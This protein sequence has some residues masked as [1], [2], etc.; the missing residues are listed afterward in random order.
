[1]EGWCKFDTYDHVWT[2]K[3]K[4]GKKTFIKRL[5]PSR[6]NRIRTIYTT[7]SS[8]NKIYSESVFINIKK[9]FEFNKSHYLQTFAVTGEDLWTH[10]ELYD[11]FQNKRELQNLLTV[12]ILIV[13]ELEKKYNF[14]HGDMNHYN[15]VISPALY[16]SLRNTE[17]GWEH[18]LF[19]YKPVLI[20]LDTS[21]GDFNG[22]LV[23]RDRDLTN[24][25]VDD[26]YNNASWI[27]FLKER[28]RKHF[29]VEDFMPFKRRKYK[30]CCQIIKHNPQYFE[31][32]IFY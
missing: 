22:V 31:N 6:V 24:K 2:T 18:P 23:P 1:M 9:I 32:K 11:L 3:D 14:R 8:E 20:D 27:F 17:S 16:P 30:T 5:K 15:I 10:E 21:I 26:F 13:S 28:I 25:F 29:D 12:L 4:H 19:Q 7:L